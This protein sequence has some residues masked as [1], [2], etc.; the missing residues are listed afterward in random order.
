MNIIPSKLIHTEDV[1]IREPMDVYSKIIEEHYNPNIVLTGGRGTGKS[2]LL[3]QLENR[4]IGTDTP[5]IYTRF[6]PAGLAGFGITKN[7]SEV[8]NDDFFKHYYEIILANKILNYIKQYYEITYQNHFI[9]KHQFIQ[10]LLNKTCHFIN[11]IMYEERSF[12]SEISSKEMT[13]EILDTFKKTIGADSINLCIDRFDWTNNRNELTQKILSQ[14]F[15]LF[16]KVVLTSDDEKL[17]NTFQEMNRK[18]FVHNDYSCMDSSEIHNHKSIKLLLLKRIE[19]FH[20]K[21][22]NT[23]I[24]IDW[25]TDDFINYMIKQT[26]GEISLM[27]T[28]VNKILND[29]SFYGNITEQRCENDLNEEIENTRQLRKMDAKP[30]KFYL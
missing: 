14:Y 12:K 23:P 18:I 11:N 20:K 25:L 26:N 2:S 7:D 1:F 30:P 22:K 17:I 15:N 4:N 6:E 19:L 16:D 28:I 21:S 29:Y 13:G 24:P 9:K 27:V 5:Y 10:E 8:F 3:Y